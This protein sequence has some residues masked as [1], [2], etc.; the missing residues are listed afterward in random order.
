MLTVLVLHFSCFRVA[1]GRAVS[2][3]SQHLTAGSPASHRAGLELP[4]KV[5]ASGAVALAG[6]L[7]KAP[8][9]SL[10]CGSLVPSWD[11]LSSLLGAGCCSWGGGITLSS[12]KSEGAGSHLRPQAPGEISE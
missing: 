5:W 9:P 1:L 8:E 10:P 12:M 4:E 11:T 6:L 7:A 3:G 2:T